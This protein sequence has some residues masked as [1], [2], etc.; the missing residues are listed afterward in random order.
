MPENRQAGPVETR[1][2][3]SSREDL[4]RLCEKSNQELLDIMEREILSPDARMDDGLFDAAQALL[5]ER[6]PVQDDTDPEASC[7]DFFQRHSE[8]FS[9]EEGEPEV[10]RPRA[11][12]LRR[13]LR[14]AAL[15]AALA[16]GVFCAGTIASGSDPISA[17]T[18]M[19]EQLARDI[20]L[21]TTGNLEVLDTPGE[22]HSMEEALS[23]HGAEG[24][25]TLGWIPSRLSLGYVV[26]QETETLSGID[27]FKI[28]AYYS[29]NSGNLMYGVSSLP[30]PV[31]EN[32][33]LEK[34][35]QEDAET[36]TLRGHTY[37]MVRNKE[38][39]QI[40]WVDNGFSYTLVASAEISVAEVEEILLS[41]KEI[42]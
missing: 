38:Y 42:E 37:Y 21:G 3:A 5:D 6:A 2:R 12:P 29:C 40:Y 25:M 32:R 20:T 10:R 22:Y 8:L 19:G 34:N 24:A 11:G 28:W 4:R 27:S 15:A 31:E 7:R 35:L 39:K 18:D 41:L 26:A 16:A 9:P 33:S 13:L 14:A 17:L 23:D 30:H 36:Y 1:L